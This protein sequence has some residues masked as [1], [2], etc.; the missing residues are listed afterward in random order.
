MNRN[1]TRQKYGEIFVVRQ[2]KEERKTNRPAWEG[3]RGKMRDSME[4]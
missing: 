2:T 3:N 1:G 4:V